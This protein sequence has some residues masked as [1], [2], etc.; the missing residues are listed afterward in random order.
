MRRN[1]TYYINHLDCLGALGLENGV[2]PDGQLKASS[3]WDSYL[4]IP[5]G[6]LGSPRSWS[7]RVNDANQWYEVDL[8]SENTKLTG[9][10]TQGRGDHPQWVTK[11][12]LQYSK[13]RATFNYYREKGAVK[14][15]NKT[16]KLINVTVNR[17]FSIY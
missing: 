3:E 1:S 17:P 16:E 13:D 14:V 10:A 11:Y 12:K 15:S 2:I 8:G 9:T 4:N 6:R 7:A 5:M